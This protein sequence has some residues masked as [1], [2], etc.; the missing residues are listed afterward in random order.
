MVP[1]RLTR[2]IVNGF[3]VT[4]VEG[5]FR[6]SCETAM[7]VLREKEEVL[8]TVLQTFVHDPLL[9][10]MHAET[11]AQQIKQVCTSSVHMES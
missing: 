8:Y 9:E 6:K 2:N 5:A 4:G 11:R 1:F 3:G 7:R 10:W